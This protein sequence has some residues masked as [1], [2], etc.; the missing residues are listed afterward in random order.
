M[1]YVED[2]E[3]LAKL[4]TANMVALEAKYHTKCLVGLYN[5][6]R[7]AK[8]GKFKDTDD[9]EVTSGIS[10]AELVMSI[11]ETQQMEGKSTCVQ[12]E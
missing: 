10:F 7:K 8:D 2:T 9:R 4:S 12:I 1:C 11:K 5:Y 6:A 3:L